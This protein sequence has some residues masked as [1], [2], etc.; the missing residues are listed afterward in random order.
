VRVGRKIRGFFV[1]LP[2]SL[3]SCMSESAGSPRSGHGRIFRARR[4]CVRLFIRQRLAGLPWLVAC[5]SVRGVIGG[6]GCGDLRLSSASSS[7]SGVYLRDASLSPSPDRLVGDRV[8]PSGP[9]EALDG[10]G[11]TTTAFLS[12]GR[13]GGL[14]GGKSPFRRFYLVGGGCG[15]RG[16]LWVRACGLVVFSPF[17]SRLGA[18]RGDS[19][20]LRSGRR[21]RHPPQR[22]AESN[23]RR[24]W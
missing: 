7:L 11:R 13:K 18:P 19:P 2:A 6:M 23:G 24:S 8:L 3:H 10:R 1:L 9:V 22:Q 20:F 12:S 4:L 5:C 17:A 14:G 16:A 21:F 15:H